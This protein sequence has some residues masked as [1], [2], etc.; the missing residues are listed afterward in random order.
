M[1]RFLDSSHPDEVQQHTTALTA[2]RLAANTAYRFAV[3]FL[4]VIGD[5]LGLSL[6]SMGAAASLGEFTGLAGPTVGRRI[7][8]ANRRSAMVLGLGV[9]TA[10][11]VLAG[12]AQGFVMIAGAF[13][14]LSI[15]KLVFDGA[16]GTWIADR[17]SYRLR[18]QVVGL[19]E[20]SWA[21]AL[22]IGVPILGVVTVL[23]SW[24]VAYFVIAA[25]LAALALMLHRRL[26]DDPPKPHGTVAGRLVVSRSVVAGYGAFGLL[27][28]GA[29]CVFV[30]LGKWLR[31]A[32]G[33]STGSIAAIS[34]VLGLG[35]LLAST[36]AVRITDRIGKRPAIM[37][38]AALMMPAGLLIGIVGHHAL[39]GIA[40]LAA[41]I[42]G[43]EFA[44]VSFIPLVNELQPTARATGFGIAAGI[45]TVGR[46]VAA[47]VSTRLYTTHG[48]GASGSLGAGCAAGVFLLLGA[49]VREPS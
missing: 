32:F 27:M 48:A 19:T 30:V 31:D 41:Y 47:I 7:D 14:L 2:S 13:V 43:F 22:L 1:R 36:G 49:L 10:A 35:E 4:S 21:G 34:I 9:L 12:S 16:M 39:V 44:I 6:T 37:G 46:G 33:F 28:T 11:T 24:R 23:T 8:A 3:P 17:V 25:A 40:L 26:A 42:V 38:G 18:G 45:G 29:N 15:G 5:S 20:T